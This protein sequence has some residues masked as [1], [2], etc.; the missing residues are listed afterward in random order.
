MGSHFASRTEAGQL[1]AERLKERH[2]AKPVALALP[3]GG[4]PVA[5]EIAKVLQA[6]LDLLLVRK[7]GV[8]YQP[9][10]ALGAVVDGDTP[11]VVVN[12]DI[13][14]HANVSDEEFEVLKAHELREIER[15]RSSYLKGRKRV[16]VK[17]MTAIVIDDGIATGATVRAALKALRLA[18]PD[19][20]VLA[21]PVA[22]KDTLQQLRSEVDEIVCIESPELF[23]SISPYYD[24]FQQVSDQQVIAWLAEGDQI[25]TSASQD[26]AD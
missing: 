20:L 25:A 6:P 16:S 11:Q 8:P 12:E 13:K 21:V 17:G 26:N 7:I 4:V 24:D 10:L 3:R 1:L 18:E 23:Y 9:E 22:P 2:Y 19:R 14:Q 15:R 5:L